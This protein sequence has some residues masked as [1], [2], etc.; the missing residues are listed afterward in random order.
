MNN[1]PYT[2]AAGTAAGALVVIGWLLSLFSGH[3]IVEMLHW[4]AMP[5]TV[6]DAI[7]GLAIGLIINYSHGAPAPAPG[8]ADLTRSSAPVV[9]ADPPPAALGKAAMVPGATG[10]TGAAS[11]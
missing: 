2:S 11:S 5:Q 10:A 1:A 9:I 3:V 4:D 7:A 8:T 6:M